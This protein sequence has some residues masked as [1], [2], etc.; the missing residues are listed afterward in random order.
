[1]VPKI[2]ICDSTFQNCKSP[3]REK[4][5]DRAALGQICF[6]K[7][8]ID[9]L[10]LLLHFVVAVVEPQL[11]EEEV[12]VSQESEPLTLPEIS[13]QEEAPSHDYMVKETE[14]ITLPQPVPAVKEKVTLTVTD[15]S[16]IAASVEF[17][18]EP[19]NPEFGRLVS[20]L[21]D[22]SGVCKINA[23]QQIY[24]LLLRTVNFF[25][26]FGSCNSYRLVKHSDDLGQISSPLAAIFS[27]TLR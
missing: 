12:N 9:E 25:P 8:L 5:G 1:M 27:M 23:R 11:E 3:F 18:L 20:S 22:K 16:A 4:V 13:S 26:D 6:P 15:P 21:K 17:D 7:V 10:I 14:S 2:Q 19:E 24:Q